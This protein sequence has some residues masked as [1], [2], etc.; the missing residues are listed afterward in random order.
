MFWNKKKKV[1][2]TIQ[3]TDQNFAEIVTNSELPVFLD[4]WAPWCG[5]CQVLGPIVDELATEFK[6]SVVVGKINVDQNPGL[7][8][9]FKVKS[10][11]TMMFV[12][13]GQLIERLSSMVPKP[14]LQE[15]L[16]DLIALEVPDLSAAT[17]EE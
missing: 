9:H 3:I 11:P 1:V 8:Q 13:N 17:E 5:P 14:N 4:F 16:H 12:K 10:I 2:D 6:D 7:S 15:M